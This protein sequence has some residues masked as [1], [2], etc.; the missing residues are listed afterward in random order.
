MEKER[1]RKGKERRKNFNVP[2]VYRVEMLHFK[3]G[4]TFGSLLPLARDLKKGGRV[5]HIRKRYKESFWAIPI[6]L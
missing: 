2:A 1:E 6:H 5:V 3:A 4:K